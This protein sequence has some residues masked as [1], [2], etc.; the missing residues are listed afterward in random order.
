MK[1][2]FNWHIYRKKEAYFGLSHYIL[3]KIICNCSTVNSNT[4]L[5]TKKYTNADI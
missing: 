5:N 4:G 2:F 3:R 1:Y